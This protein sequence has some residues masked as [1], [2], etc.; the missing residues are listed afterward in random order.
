V[1]IKQYIDDLV[2]GGRYF[3]TFEEVQRKFGLSNTA[4]VLFLSL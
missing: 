1:N 2:A 3:F 4:G